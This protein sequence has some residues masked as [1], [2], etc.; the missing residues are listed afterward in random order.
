MIRKLLMATSIAM[1]LATISPTHAIGLKDLKSPVG[2]ESESSGSAE[3]SQEKIVQSYREALTLVMGAQIEL[4][5]ALDSKEDA[6]ALQTQ[7]DSLG[8]GSLDGKKN[9]EEVSGSSADADARIQELID[10]G[11]TVSEEGREHYIKGLALYVQGLVATKDMANETTEFGKEAK[12]EI[13]SA[14][15]MKKAKVTSKLAAGT[16]LVSEIP[17]F[18]SRLVGNLQDL[19][20]FAKSAGIPVPDDATDALASL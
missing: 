4:L 14:S 18:T 3:V 6:A 5:K 16:Y 2:G 1:V 13:G 17:R 15:M 19:T 7:A 9:L 8:S 10:A 12:A 20:A 11:A